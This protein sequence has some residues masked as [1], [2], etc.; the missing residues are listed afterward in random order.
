[1]YCQ[2]RDNRYHVNLFYC[3][4][5][6]LQLI[7][8]HADQISVE[9]KME[10]TCEYLELESDSSMVVHGNMV[11]PYI[12]LK[13][14]YDVQIAPDAWLKT[15]NLK[16]VGQTVFIEGHVKYQRVSKISLED[17]INESG[18]GLYVYIQGNLHTGPN[19]CIQSQCASHQSNEIS[20][21]LQLLVE[22]DICNH[23]T[24]EAS[25]LIKIKS[26]SLLSRHTC[27]KDA[28]DRYLQGF[29]RNQVAERHYNLHPLNIKLADT[30][31]SC[32]TKTDSSV[33]FTKTWNKHRGLIISP[34]IAY[35]MGG[36]FEDFGQV[37]CK[38]IVMDTS[39]NICVEEKS[40]CTIGCISG[41]CRGETKIY[42]QLKLGSFKSFKTCKLSIFEKGTIITENGG[43]IFIDDCFHNKSLVYNLNQKLLIHTGVF[44][45]EK[46]CQI[47]SND[48][49][50]IDICKASKSFEGSLEAK[51]LHFVVS[52]PVTENAF[53]KA[54]NSCAFKFT[55]NKNEEAYGHWNHKGRIEVKKGK[56]VMSS[57]ANLHDRIEDDMTVEGNMVSMGFVGPS[58]TVSLKS[59]SNITLRPDAYVLQNQ[60]YSSN[61]GEHIFPFTAGNLF[62]AKGS[63]ITFCAGKL[64]TH[65]DMSCINTWKHYGLIKVEKTENVHTDTCIAVGCFQNHGIFE[66]FRRLKV[67]VN[68][69]MESHSP[70][71]A[72][73]A[74]IIQGKGE[75]YNRAGSILQC[76]YG[77]VEIRDVSILQNEYGA[78]IDGE[79]IKL[80]T[81]SGNIRKREV[82]TTYDIKNKGLIR[83]SGDVMIVA[84]NI[85][86]HGTI[87][88]FLSKV[89]IHYTT[90]RNANTKLEGVLLSTYSLVVCIYNAP[91][92]HCSFR[93]GS[94]WDKANIILP[95][96]GMCVKCFKGAVIFHTQIEGDANLLVESLK[97]VTTMKDIIVPCLTLCLSVSNRYNSSYNQKYQ[98]TIFLESEKNDLSEYNDNCCSIKHSHK[99]NFSQKYYHADV[100]IFNG[101]VI[102][103]ENI[104]VE[105]DC[106]TMELKV[107]TGEDSEI[108]VKQNFACETFL[109]I[110]GNLTISSSTLITASRFTTTER[111]LCKI[112]GPSDNVN[113]DIC[114]LFTFGDIEL[115]GK[116][117]D[118]Q[119]EPFLFGMESQC[120]HIKI[121]GIVYIHN[122]SLQTGQNCN[123]NI[124]GQMK[125]VGYMFIGGAGEVTFG[126]LSNIECDTITYQ[127]TQE[128]LDSAKIHLTL[129]GSVFVHGPVHFDY[130]DDIVMCGHLTGY[131][132]SANQAYVKMTTSSVTEISSVEEDREMENSYIRCT[133]NNLLTERGSL[134]K[135]HS[136]G[137]RTLSSLYISTW[138]HH[139]C[140][141]I[142]NPGPKKSKHE[143]RCQFSYFI[144]HGKCV[145]IDSL[146]LVCDRM[147][148]N[149]VSLSVTDVLDIIVDGNILNNTGARFEC[150]NGPLSIKTTENV[151]NNGQLISNDVNQ[152]LAAVISNTGVIISCKST[153]KL[154]W[155]TKEKACIDG[156]VKSPSKIQFSS[157]FSMEFHFC[158]VGG[159]SRNPDLF[160]M[161]AKGMAFH[162]PRGSIILESNIEGRQKSA[163]LSVFCRDGCTMRN[164][165]TTNSFYL[166]RAFEDEKMIG[167]QRLKVDSHLETKPVS[168]DF[169]LWLK[170]DCTFVSRNLLAKMGNQNVTFVIRTDDSSKLV[171][172]EH[173]FNLDSLLLIHGNIETSFYSKIQARS[174]SLHKDSILKV[175]SEEQIDPMC[176]PYEPATLVNDECKLLSKMDIKIDGSISSF[177]DARIQTSIISNL[178]D[179]FIK[180]EINVSHLQIAA[181]NDRSLHFYGMV[182]SSGWLYLSRGRIIHIDDQ[183]VLRCKSFSCEPQMKKSERLTVH[184][185][186]HI[187]GPAY[188]V[189]NSF[190]ISRRGQVIIKSE[191]SNEHVV[192]EDMN[193]VDIYGRFEC[194][195]QGDCLVDCKKSISLLET[196]NCVFSL[197]DCNLTSSG[198]FRMDETCKIILE[199][200]NLYVGNS[201]EEDT[202]IHGSVE[203]SGE[204]RGQQE[205]E[206]SSYRAVVEIEGH[207][208]SFSNLRIQN[209]HT[210][211]L[212]AAQS[213]FVDSD[214]KVSNVENLEI[215]ATSIDFKG[216]IEN[217]PMIKILAESSLLLDKE[218]RIDNDQMKTAELYLKIT[219]TTIEMKGQINY[220]NSKDGEAKMH[221]DASNMLIMGEI[222]SEGEIEIETDCSFVNNGQV[223]CTTIGIKA[224]ICL[225]CPIHFDK[226]KLQ[227]FPQL[228]GE[229]QKTLVIDG[230][231]CIVVGSFLHA[232]SNDIKSILKF[233]FSAE[234]S[235]IPQASDLDRW[236]SVV[237][238]FL[239]KIPNAKT[240][241]DI[242]KLTEQTIKIQQVI[243]NLNVSSHLCEDVVKMCEKISKG[244]LGQFDVDDM[245][246]SLDN[247]HSFYSKLIPFELNVDFVSIK[248]RSLKKRVKK[249]A[250][251]LMNKIFGPNSFSKSLE[252]PQNDF[253]QGIR[254]DSFINE[255]K[256]TDFRSDEHL[257]FA[258]LKFQGRTGLWKN[259]GYIEAC[260]D[261]IISAS[262][263][264]QLGGQGRIMKAITG[265]I[266]LTGDSA[267]VKNLESKHLHIDVSQEA[268][269]QSVKTEGE[270]IVH[271]NSATIQNIDAKTLH[272][273]TQ[274][275]VK[276]N[277]ANIR[278]DMS[279]TSKRIDAYNVKSKQLDLKASENI[280]LDN[281]ST[282]GIATLERGNTIDAKNIKVTELNATSKGNTDFGE[283]QAEKM[284]AVSKCGNITLNEKIKANKANIEAKLGDISLTGINK[285]ANHEFGCLN[286]T[287]RALEDINKLLNRSDVYK[288]LKI[289]DHLGLIVEDQ[290]V[291]IATQ[292]KAQFSLSIKAAS[293][294]V[295][296]GM[297]AKNL[298]LVTTNGILKIDKKVKIKAKENVRLT[299]R[300]KLRLCERSSVSAGQN[301]NLESEKD[302]VSLSASELDVGNGINIKAHHDI[303]ISSD[304]NGGPCKKS[305]L[306]AGRTNKEQP[307]IDLEA[308]RNI[309][310][311]ASEISSKGE[312]IFKAG[313]N[314]SITA[315][316]HETTKRKTKSSWLGLCK[317]TTETTTTH[318]EKFTI[319]SRS[320]VFKAGGSYTSVAG[321]IKSELGNDIRATGGISMLD[322]QTTTKTKTTSSF[323]GIKYNRKDES[324]QQSQGTSLED[325]SAEARTSIVSETSNIQWHGSNLNSAGNVS[326]SAEMGEITHSP[327]LLNHETN[328]MGIKF[329][330]QKSTND[331]GGTFGIEA[332]YEH[333]SNQSTSTD[334]TNIGGDYNVRAKK[335]SVLN[336][337]NIDVKGNMNVR[338]DDLRIEGASL[339]A[340]DKSVNIGIGV[341]SSMAKVSANYE[342]G[343]I[344]TQQMQ[345]LHVSGTLHLDNI[346]HVTIDTSNIDSGGLT[347]QVD[348][349]D[350]KSRS[351]R[352]SRVKLGVTA[353]IDLVTR[354]LCGGGID[355]GLEGDDR[356]TPPTSIDVNGGSKELSVET[357]ETKGATMAFDGDVHKFA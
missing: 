273:K 166:E 132:I 316:Q 32:D 214:S 1:M 188:F 345:K 25:K 185:Q 189:V 124:G 291:I 223:H 68:K 284:N 201:R 299:S 70:I 108:I 168:Q 207:C 91:I 295:R 167:N 191:Y 58:V 160:V 286:L 272:V 21:S 275:K 169:Y 50:E 105:S 135:L 138:Q 221:F 126:K 244:G 264:K 253:A 74:L 206:K 198:L 140:L 233:Q 23:G 79:S 338:T 11:C 266:I 111:S 257:S 128:E 341:K 227:Q 222:R 4:V 134:I 300:G 12:S 145:N 352:K 120:G 5:K 98:E 235:T 347:S 215:Q 64:K 80:S 219:A 67:I 254:I 62:T 249:V 303:I 335:V 177:K 89:E 280:T 305:K 119:S 52:A 143:L 208:V 49:L 328:E 96:K 161:P 122:M 331:K 163:I 35:E 294:D 104:I 90:R 211:A 237:D 107:T 333:R 236:K 131:G 51:D 18:N 85:K 65:F 33:F 355:I 238:S 125:L 141:E 115:N 39:G 19:S 127:R 196:S 162:C 351:D 349:L 154:Y 252:F 186:L 323:L 130:I 192:L 225:N 298:E 117:S 330:A 308:E 7:R 155:I 307:A 13:S 319:A 320:N 251:N 121:R 146:Y 301:I 102:R 116:L 109:I 77:I 42:G 261:I 334:S 10:I 348:N 329:N 278:Q 247:A 356:N 171:C 289:A 137:E 302:S 322:L 81:A 165:V 183:A 6:G 83:S 173:I 36:D 37:K 47:I 84:G 268:I 315:N 243:C 267:E 30:F 234:R 71:L 101:S 44:R 337:W 24:I 93:G 110:N 293:I 205:D 69:L 271:G 149:F 270:A 313:N 190:Y 22:G 99:T 178:G 184:G 100:C 164:N 156:I 106:N 63:E 340:C 27:H 2:L 41:N 97:G 353:D 259:D 195:I 175:F 3:S 269:L 144:N 354:S 54:I 76:K 26:G 43:N 290:N 246:T 55:K 350:I 224:P 343:G 332:I 29:I 15:T 210:A 20:G 218:S 202:T 170:E 118:D 187:M 14:K 199:K 193:T 327:R 28:K 82:S 34:E 339:E 57:T 151:L 292:Q 172:Y 304:A 87:Q 66:G 48:D 142:I 288:D 158:C 346:K 262:K 9:S 239:S 129:S 265:S 282:K 56:I 159:I 72:S 181:A 147:L 220:L 139:G 209:I 94:D 283:K 232:N 326:E 31:Q 317:R 263:I 260:G 309:R 92:F 281:V 73:D 287:T 250:K 197:R 86:N 306:S 242:Q 285:K 336:S 357:L 248:Y 245:I 231:L 179:V 229:N 112:N 95:K 226:S 40:I 53:I 17:A 103:I 45:Q 297:D 314:I 152:I 60:L 241:E 150:T 318:V 114:K 256:H 277:T 133:M 212:F 153:V 38:K 310:I 46:G 123:I 230:L 8:I 325:S 296:K 176:F 204:I 274:Q 217:T 258:S 321:N 342:K 136:R 59:R 88:S 255:G 203:L 182:N 312:N 228:G 200:G 157:P 276:I 194:Q 113:D 213:L 78:S 75:V 61:G 311:H 216:L 148:S 16:I 180:G 240:P 279:V 324:S 344:T 174:I